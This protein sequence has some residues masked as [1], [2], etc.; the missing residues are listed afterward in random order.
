LWAE[1]WSDDPEKA[2]YNAIFAHF[3]AHG[4]NGL[5]LLFKGGYVCTT[6]VP[7]AELYDETVAMGVQRQIK[8]QP[9]PVTKPTEKR[10]GNCAFIQWRGP[11]AV[12]HETG[13]CSKY[14]FTGRPRVYL[15]SEPCT[16]W[17]QKSMQKQQTEQHESKMSV[18]D[19]LIKLHEGRKKR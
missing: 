13:T 3:K 17:R 18:I 16:E 19:G 6:N 10:C 15:R 5:F 1:P 11:N 4:K 9:K 12:T 14:R 2:L 8:Q 7:G